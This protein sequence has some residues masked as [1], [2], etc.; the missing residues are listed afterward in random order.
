MKVKILYVLFL[1]QKA[2]D[3]EIPALLIEKR[4][5]TLLIMP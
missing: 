4:L 1:A 2:K 3:Q 5:N